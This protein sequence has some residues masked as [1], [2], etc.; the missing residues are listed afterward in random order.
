MYTMLKEGIIIKTINDLQFTYEINAAINAVKRIPKDNIVSKEIIDELFGSY[1][2]NRAVIYDKE[3]DKFYSISTKRLLD[4]NYNS[5]KVLDD[6][7]IKIQ[8]KYKEIYPKEYIFGLE[9]YKEKYPN[10]SFD[11]LHCDDYLIE[12]LYYCV[13]KEK[14]FLEYFVKEGYTQLVLDN[15]GNYE[16]LDV[17]KEKNTVSK[18]FAL[19]EE[20]ISVL[21][22]E[23]NKKVYY[24]DIKH[25][26]DLYNENKINANQAKD[27]LKHYPSESY[28]IKQLLKDNQYTYEEIIEYTQRCEQYN[29]LTPR[30]TL[31]ELVETIAKAKQC[32]MKIDKFP[33]DLVKEYDKLLHIESNYR[34]AQN[35]KAFYECYSGKDKDRDKLSFKNDYYEIKPIKDVDTYMLLK[36][37][38]RYSI[39]NPIYFYNEIYAMLIDRKKDCICK[40]I[41]AYPHRLKSEIKHS[42]KRVKRFLKAYQKYLESI[43]YEL[44][45]R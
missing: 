29:N 14:P 34:N 28:Y 7:D 3:S 35:K 16:E 1:N 4:N 31:L 40:V 27:I 36:L 45:K 32:N 6:W 20:I 24:S 15:L 37:T 8:D 19:P 11:L 22:E 42:S 26:A 41:D 18:I 38:N 39:N 2:N 12:L 17:S 10:N 23:R 25:F 33:N 9:D 21:K 13:Y 30:R 44:Y 5:V 43:E